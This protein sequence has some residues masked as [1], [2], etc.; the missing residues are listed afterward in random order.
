MIKFVIVEDNAK[1]VNTIKEIIN[2]E[3]YR[4]DTEVKTFEIKGYNR[5]LASLISNPDEKTIYILD[6]ELEN[7]KSGIEIASII[8]ENDW[9][10]EIIF[11]TNHDK[12]FETAHRSVY[13]VF[14]FIEKYHDLEKRLTKDIKTI[15]NKNIDKR[16]FTYKG[17]NIDLQ[18]YLN[19]IKYI[20]RDKGERKV[21]IVT[22]KSSFSINL[23]VKEIL[24]QLD[25]RFKIIHR[26]CIVNT[27]KVSIYDWNNSKIIINYGILEKIIFL[28]EKVLIYMIILLNVI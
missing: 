16:M 12:M 19:S 10:S 26:S 21:V 17:R 2:K 14:D 23:G 8:R 22:D 5:Q 13:E 27:D 6:I 25:D 20:Y 3:K 15:L 11:I 24:E 18:L 4:I 7:S 1:N 9:D 28:L